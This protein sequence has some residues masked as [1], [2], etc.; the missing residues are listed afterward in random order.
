MRTAIFTIINNSWID[1]FNV[2]I[3]SWIHDKPTNVDFILFHDDTFDLNSLNY[4]P[5]YFIKIPNDVYL[6]KKQKNQIFHKTNWHINSSRIFIIEEY[7]NIYDQMIYLD[8]DTIVLDINSLINYESDKSICAVKNEFT[9]EIIELLQKYNK[10]DIKRYKR[11]TDQI[12]I[13]P[14][15]YINAGVL[16]L[17]MTKIRK[18]PFNIKTLFIKMFPT[19]TFND[20]DFINI[21]FSNDIE[22]LDREYN[23]MPLPILKNKNSEIIIYDDKIKSLYSSYDNKLKVIHYLSGWRL[24][25]NSI[26]NEKSK[27]LNID[28][29]IYEYMKFFH[30]TNNL[31]INFTKKVL[32]NLNE[33]NFKN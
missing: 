18:L 23:Y 22:Y 20:Q 5:D 28:K 33:L 30:K 10:I 9:E 7:K 32:Y 13:N 1:I 24:W 2:F 3:E 21:I 25:D 14:N 17:N 12:E 26:L 8:A 31:S 11:Y 6:L 4:K 15:G 19:L 27:L 16:I 29:I